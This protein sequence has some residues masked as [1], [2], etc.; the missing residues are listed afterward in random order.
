M[1][2]RCA[3]KAQSNGSGVIDPGY[4]ADPTSENLLQLFH[5]F[6]D[7]PE[8][9]SYRRDLLNRFI[10]I[11]NIHAHEDYPTLLEAAN[12]YQNK[13]RHSGRPIRH[14]KQIGTTLLVKGLEYDHAI[15]LH[16][17]S[18]NK[19]E[20]YVAM[21]RGS[22]SLTLTTEKDHLCFGKGSVSE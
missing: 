19:K 10:N 13:F 3:G 9:R 7:N 21:T 18:L 22:K 1:T 5:L 16:A 14:T 12:S 17:D 20:L 4:L 15:V 11:L 6:G 8:T 2:P